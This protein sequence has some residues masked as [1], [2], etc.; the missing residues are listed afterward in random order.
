M[1]LLNVF[2]AILAMASGVFMLRFVAALATDK[3]ITA[4]QLQFRA[5]EIPPPGAA[6]SG[7]GFGGVACSKDSELGYEECPTLPVSWS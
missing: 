7:R 2:L 6:L 4:S 1:T 5:I 3:L